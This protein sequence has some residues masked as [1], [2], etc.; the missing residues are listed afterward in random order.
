MSKN[1][2]KQAVETVEPV[3]VSTVTEATPVIEVLEESKK[4]VPSVED[5][6]AALTKTLEWAD[7]EFAGADVSW[8]VLGE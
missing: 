3:E 4:P 2:Q 6:L 8:A 5:V 7:G 1:K